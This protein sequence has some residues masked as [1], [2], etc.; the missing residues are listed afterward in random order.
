M[1]PTKRLTF[2]LLFYIGLADFTDNMQSL[3]INPASLK[4][5]DAG[6]SFLTSLVA[7]PI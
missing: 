4:L 6:Q 5:L 1:E 2:K 3:L 7:S